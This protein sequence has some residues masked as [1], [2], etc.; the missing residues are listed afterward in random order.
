VPQLSIRLL[1][2]AQIFT[3]VFGGHFPW[4]SYEI[5]TWWQ[6]D[7]V[8]QTWVTS[9]KGHNFWSDRWIIL[10][11]LHEFSEAVFLRVAMDSLLDD[12][13]VWSAKLEKR[14]KR[15]ITFDPTVGLRSSFTWVSRGYFPCGCCGITTRWWGGLVG[16]TL[17][18]CQKGNKFWSDSWIPPKFL[19]EFSEAVYFGVGMESLLGDGEV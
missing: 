14:L 7:L 6:G 13:E 5:T 19:L 4:G 16:H 3:W 10:N 18:T 15:A 12:E 11:C 1:H 9:Q 8:G 2:R 17:V